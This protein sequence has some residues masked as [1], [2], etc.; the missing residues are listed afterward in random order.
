MLRLCN[1]IKLQPRELCSETFLSNLR[2]KYQLFRRL[3][4]KL[5]MI[6]IQEKPKEGNEKHIIN[7]PPMPNTHVHTLV[8]TNTVLIIDIQY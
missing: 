6:D 5:K 3:E 8:K 4:Q 2:F 7:K 1:T